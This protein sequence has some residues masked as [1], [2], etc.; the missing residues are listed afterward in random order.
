MKIDANTPLFVVSK[1]GV[2]TEM[3]GKIV[4]GRYCGHNFFRDYELH[5][6]K[7]G[8]EKAATRYQLLRKLDGIRK[9]IERMTNEQLQQIV[10]TL[11]N[12]QI[13]QIMGFLDK[14]G[15]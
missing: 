8:A 2:M 9:R 15:I 4:C 11:E 12:Q 13:E 14:M 10:D 5:T 7:A 1:S 3:N 6:D